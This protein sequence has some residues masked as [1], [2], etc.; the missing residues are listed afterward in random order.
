MYFIASSLGLV[1]SETNGGRGNGQP[2][3]ELPSRDVRDERNARPTTLRPMAITT[4]QARTQIVDDLGAA[5]D[6]IALAVACLGA[7]H[8]LLDD[9][10]ADRLEADL[11]RPVQRA[12]GRAKR[13][14]AAFA[15]RH[16]LTV[17]DGP[18]PSPG[19][20]PRV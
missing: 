12:L 19:A 9:L 5:I 4:A 17:P 10:T 15:G 2:S 1:A 8:E 11:F 3:H 7:A 13:T 20:P 18:Q 14:R 16:A 6:Q